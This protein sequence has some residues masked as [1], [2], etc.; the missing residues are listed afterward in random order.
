MPSTIERD[1]ANGRL[2]K[3]RSSYIDTQVFWGVRSVNPLGDFLE[4]SVSWRIFCLASWLSHTQLAP[5]LKSL[6]QHPKVVLSVS[7]KRMG[8]LPQMFQLVNKSAI[9]KDKDLGPWDPFLFLATK[10]MAYLGGGVI[11]FW[12]SPGSLKLNDPDLM[13]RVLRWVVK[14][15]PTSHRIHGT[16]IFTYILP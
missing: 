10:K 6:I 14:K 2:S 9:P 8:S 3:L 1:L 7:S 5:F 16:G 13:S 15:P 12:R 4:T 11:F